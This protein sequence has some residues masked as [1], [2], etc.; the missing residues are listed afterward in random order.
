MF[1]DFYVFV[2][3]FFGFSEFLFLGFLWIFFLTFFRWKEKVEALKIIVVNQE[4]V[5]LSCF[6]IG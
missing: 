6:Y 1:S 2:C 3:I 5:E 4:F